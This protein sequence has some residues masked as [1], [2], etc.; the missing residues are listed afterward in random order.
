MRNS[1]RARSSMTRVPFSKFSCFMLILCMTKALAETQSSLPFVKKDEEVK[2][3]V[4][5]IM[6]YT[7]WVP[8]PT[9][10]QLCIVGPTKHASL[11][12]HLDSNDTP[13]SVIIK[14]Q[15]NLTNTLGMQC[16]VIYF[17]DIP[18]AEQQ[19]IIAARQNHP[20]L[21]LSENNPSCELGS[22]FC[23]NIE[24]SPI[25]FIVNLDSLARS[26]VHVNP[27]VLLLGSKNRVAQ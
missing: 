1:S 17:G 24:A 16:D 15:N 6:S 8:P 23:L 5:G 18:P 11:L 19:K 14:K 21:V 26:G 3:I 27:N 22:S 20:I 9:P 13:N 2:Q 7:R 4:L 12:E 10:V 25:T